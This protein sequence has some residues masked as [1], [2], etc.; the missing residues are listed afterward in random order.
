MSTDEQCLNRCYYCGKEIRH[1]VGNSC[2]IGPVPDHG[3][4]CGACFF[5]VHPTK[6]YLLDALYIAQ[7]E[8]SLFMD[9]LRYGF[10]R[11]SGHRDTWS[12]VERE[13]DYAERQ[14]EVGWV[15]NQDI[16]EACAHGHT[17]GVM[18]SKRCCECGAGVSERKQAGEPEVGTLE[19]SSLSQVAPIPG[20]KLEPTHGQRLADLEERVA[21][22]ELGRKERGSRYEVT[23][24]LVLRVE[25]E[26]YAVL[27]LGGAALGIVGLGCPE[28][29]EDL[30]KALCK[31]AW[32]IAEVL[33][34]KVCDHECPDEAEEIG[35]TD[36]PQL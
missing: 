14:F 33:L 11:V 6:S 23:T 2:L 10:Q 12:E 22:L 4:A 1:R 28:E 9:Q 35:G 21:V 30:Q 20:Y 8:E 32:L 15:M 34:D 25:P 29:D 17:G 18:T 24:D 19:E 13:R 3:V 36:D 16:G 31:Y 7:W 5:A 27:F 26:G